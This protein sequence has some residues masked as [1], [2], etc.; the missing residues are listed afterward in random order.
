MGR[1]GRVGLRRLTRNQVYATRTGGSNPSLSARRSCSGNA[2]SGA[3][4]LAGEMTEWLKVHD[5]KSCV[6]S[7]ALPRVRIPLSPPD[8]AIKIGSRSRARA[9]CVGTAM[10]R[11]RT[12][13]GPGGSNGKRAYGVR[14]QPGRSQRP[15]CRV[16]RPIDGGCT[17]K[18]HR[19]LRGG[20]ACATG[21]SPRPHVRAAV[22]VQG[23]GFRVQGS[24]GDR[25][26]P[27][28]DP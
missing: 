18:Q 13:P 22:R 8:K 9:V 20:R 10:G 4:L 12:P 24:G 21:R 17:I 11:Q 2:P 6:G 1:G 26:G 19:R 28:P 27:N 5:W 15:G 14:R 16:C 23:S 25:S 3:I 7:K